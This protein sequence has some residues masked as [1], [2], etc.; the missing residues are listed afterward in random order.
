MKKI[1]ALI[2]CLLTLIPFVLMPAAAMSLS[3]GTAR[4]DSLF[5]NGTYGKSYDYVYYSP[6]REEGDD[7]KYPLLIWLHGMNSGSFARAQLQGYEFSN[8][9]SEEYQA[10]FTNTGGCFLLAPRA[11]SAPSNNWDAV[12][13]SELKELIDSFV[14]AN[15][16]NIDASRIYIAG[17]S[18]G[19]SMVWEMVTAYPKYFA[20]AMPLASITQPTLAGLNKLTDVSLWIFTSD[21]DPYI[22]NETSDVLP[23][24]EYLAGITK[25]PDGLRLTSFSEARFAD[26]SK[27]K[28]GGQVADDAEHYIW[29]A[30]TYDMFMADGITPYVFAKTVDSSGKEITLSVP[31][32]GVIDWLSKQSGEKSEK[33]AAGFFEKIKL[34]FRRIIALIKE[35]FSGI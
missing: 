4:L 2:L 34:F 16:E 33:S 23:N 6:V 28:E 3:E 22:I 17:Y 14:D 1:T 21:H 8:W 18:T 35:L 13:C 20:A 31:G 7:T 10:R 12:P 32:I 26:Y 9:A 11:A 27:K 29:E 15:R 19:G 30:V 25:R 5:K 24:F